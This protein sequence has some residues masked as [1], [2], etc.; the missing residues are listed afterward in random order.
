VEGDGEK[1]GLLFSLV[2]AD[3]F[4]FNIVTP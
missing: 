1:L 2:D 3:E 4:W